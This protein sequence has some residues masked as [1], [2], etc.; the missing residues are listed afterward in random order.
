MFKEISI[1]ETKELLG[2]AGTFA[3]DSFM[4]VS[5][6]L[7]PKYYRIYKAFQCVYSGDHQNLID[8]LPTASL[9]EVPD[10]WKVT[11]V[12]EMTTGCTMPQLDEIWSWAKAYYGEDKLERFEPVF[13][14]HGDFT[15]RIT[16]IY[17]DA[18]RRR[19]FHSSINCQSRYQRDMD[20]R[21][22]RKL[23]GEISRNEDVGAA[24][25]V[26]VD[27][28]CDM[29]FEHHFLWTDVTNSTSSASDIVKRFRPDMERILQE[30]DVSGLVLFIEVDGTYTTMGEVD[31]LKQRFVNLVGEGVEVAINVRIRDS[32]IKSITCRATLI[33]SPKYIKG[34]V[35]QDYGQYE[36]LLYESENKERGHVIVA[37]YSEEEF[38]LSRYDWGEFDRNSRGETDDHHYFDKENTLKLFNALH[39]RKPEA[40]LRTIRRRFAARL[41]SSADSRLLAFCRKEGIKFKSDYHY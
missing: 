6:C 28:V 3:S 32:Y 9:P 21:I 31:A 5:L 35:Y 16:V 7:Y 12:M 39:V 4:D 27:E 38:T 14:Y 20:I 1:K 2:Y 19:S 29:L 41:P 18:K 17:H 10:D 40:L 36:I 13:L 22:G 33:G 34:E 15:A 30:F 26:D 11:V 24:V 25:A 23:D 37:S 8:L